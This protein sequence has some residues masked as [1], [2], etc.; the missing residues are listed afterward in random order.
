MGRWGKG[1]GK[2]R[3][4]HVTIRD[5][6]KEFYKYFFMND[7]NAGVYLLPHIKPGIKTPLSHIPTAFVY[8][9]FFFCHLLGK[10]YLMVCEGVVQV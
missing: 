9:P 5:E 10:S 3:V 6:R 2:G 4:L 8:S 7:S 1:K